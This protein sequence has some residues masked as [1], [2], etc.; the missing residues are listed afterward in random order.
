M[1]LLITQGVATGLIATAPLGRFFFCNNNLGHERT[2]LLITLYTQNTL[3][4]LNTRASQCKLL[5]SLHITLY[6]FPKLLL[7]PQIRAVLRSSEIFYR[8]GIVIQLEG[9]H[10]FRDGQ[11][12]FCLQRYDMYFGINIFFH[13]KLRMRK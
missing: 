4:S 8:R 6:S 1:S 11:R 2:T 7:A 13:N 12:H 5:Y 9:H 3:Y 10:L